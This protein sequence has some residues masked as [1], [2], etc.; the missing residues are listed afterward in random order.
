[1]SET[2]SS[3]APQPRLRVQDLDV[4]YGGSQVVRGVSLEVGPGEAVAI[5]GRN[6]AGKTTTLMAV[7]GALR[8]GRGRVELEGSPIQGQEA[9]RVSRRGVAL[10]PQG[11]RIFGNLS[12]RENLLL[13]ARGGPAELRAVHQLFPILAE[14]GRNRASA[15]SGGEQQMLAI[16]RA[17]LTRPSLLLMDEPSEGLAPL[18][19][20]A[21][22]ELIR[23]LRGEQELSILIAEQNLALALEVADRVYLLER[24]EVV[25]Q[26]P[27]SE[28]A[29]DR[30]RQRRYLGV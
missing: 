26:A 10:V 29:G 6:G 30:E 12:V 9:F 16:G 4:S 27:V 21:M 7:A 13:G 25:H 19:V 3:T 22:G 14:R 28:F 2:T 8:P 18:L 20:K 24:G 11:R 15:L 1:V 5:L 17:L 23:R